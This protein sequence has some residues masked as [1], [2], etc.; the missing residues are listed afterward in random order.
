MKT[1]WKYALEVSDRQTVNMPVGS[2]MLSIQT[3]NEKPCLWVLVNPKEVGLIDI[4]I[5]IYGTGH[6]IES[7]QLTYIDTFQLSGGMLVFHAFKE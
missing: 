5:R 4:T 2:K 1:I 7:E 6:N 3:Q